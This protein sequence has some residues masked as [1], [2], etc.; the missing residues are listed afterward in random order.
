MA[1]TSTNISSFEL[2]NVIANQVQVHI[3]CLELLAETSITLHVKSTQK[4]ANVEAEILF[5]LEEGSSVCGFAT[6]IYGEMVP[7]VITTKEIAQVAL[8]NAVKK[9]KF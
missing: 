1:Q 7:G 8:E 4:K 3:K 6:D 5:S 9:F 2:K